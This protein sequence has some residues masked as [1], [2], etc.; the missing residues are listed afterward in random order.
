MKK[1]NERKRA[2]QNVK[3]PGFAN[4]ILWWQTGGIEQMGGGTLLPYL[5]AKVRLIGKK[6]LLGSPQQVFFASD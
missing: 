3:H 1:N 4:G 2:T 5:A 6:H